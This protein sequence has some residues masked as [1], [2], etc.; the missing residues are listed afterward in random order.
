MIQLSQDE[1]Y[2][3]NLTG[4][5]EWLDILDRFKYEECGGKNNTKG[6]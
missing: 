1:E 4:H 2:T 6:V 5:Q 3:Y